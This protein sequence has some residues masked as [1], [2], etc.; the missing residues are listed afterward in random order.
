ML[1]EEMGDRA[2]CPVTWFLAQALADGVFEDPTSIN[3]MEAKDIPQGTTRY[4]F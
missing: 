2:L 1:Y 3:K 4:I